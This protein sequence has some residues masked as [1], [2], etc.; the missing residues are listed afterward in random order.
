MAVHVIDVPGR[1]GQTNDSNINKVK[2]FANTILLSM[3]K[4]KNISS[5]FED[6]PSANPNFY[7]IPLIGEVHV[8]ADWG[9]AGDYSL[10]ELIRNFRISQTR[11]ITVQ[12]A[13]NALSANGI[14]KGDYLTIDLKQKVSGGEV[15][16]VKLGDKIYI[17]KA[18]FKGN[19][20]RLET[21]DPTADPL[22]FDARTPGFE[23]VGKVVSVI[24]EL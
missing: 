21:A 5:P 14:F 7:N 12:T 13:D 3:K 11:Y 1:N 18:F 15:C 10:G 22:I 16:A 4:N 17:R 8:P 9:D 23:V 6:T 2:L 24:R 20:I 19:F